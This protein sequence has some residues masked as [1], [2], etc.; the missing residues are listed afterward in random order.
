MEGKCILGR[1]ALQLCRKVEV[2]DGV[3]RVGRN[4]EGDVEPASCRLGE[5]LVLDPEHFLE[6]NVL[7]EAAHLVH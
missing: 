6:N 5:A 4:I 7:S 1:A 3:G 2:G